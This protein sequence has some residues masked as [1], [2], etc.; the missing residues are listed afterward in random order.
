MEEAKRKLFEKAVKKFTLSEVTRHARI[1]P[2]QKNLVELISK[3]P[4][5]G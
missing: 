1:G 2:G 3:Y 5:N 4:G